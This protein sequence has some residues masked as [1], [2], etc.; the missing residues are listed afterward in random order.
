MY[1]N[2][3]TSINEDMTPLNR[4]NVLS[5]I[6]EYRVY[7]FYIGRD[8][9]VGKAMESPLREDSHPS[10][11]IYNRFGRLKFKDHSTGVGGDIFNFLQLLFNCT[12]YEALMQI[13]KDFN[14][15]LQHSGEY[16]SLIKHKGYTT[17]RSYVPKA[18]TTIKVKVR[19]WNNVDKKYWAKYNITR[20]ILGLYKVYPLQRAY[21]NDKG[22][23]YYSRFNPGYCYQFCKDENYTYKIYKPLGE[24][25]KRWYSNTDSSVLQG[26]D[27]LPA[28]A[29]ILIL[30][31][32]LK[33]V[34]VLHSLGYASISM[35]NEIS[36]VK[37]NV[38]QQLRERFSTIYVLQDFDYAGVKGTNQLRKK[39]TDLKY[40]FI[41]DFST[42]R[43]GLK[44]ISDYIAS[45]GVI[46]TI[47]YL[48]TKLND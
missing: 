13:N 15:D 48:K 7:T 42:R 29:D 14:L 23:Y 11:S 44:D 36:S 21:I 40:F 46:K 41:Q 33:D 47:N 43:N 37:E 22:V 12:F 26:W 24:K 32:S 35:Q 45:E 39:F 31:K 4:D 8:F 30:T 1:N 19:P 34:M 3:I 17:T 20:I 9:V 16:N 25:G 18:G 6:N 2:K 27:Q 10:F 38:M 5:R 28:K